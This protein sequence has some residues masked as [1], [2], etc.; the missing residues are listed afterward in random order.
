M[1]KLWLGHC[2]VAI[3]HRS[4]DSDQVGFFLLASSLAR[5]DENDAQS[6]WTFCPCIPCFIS[7]EMPTFPFSWRNIQ[8][9]SFKIIRFTMEVRILSVT[10]TSIR[11]FDHVHETETAKEVK[12]FKQWDP[13]DRSKI[14]QVLCIKEPVKQHGHCLSIQSVVDRFWLEKHRGHAV[15]FRGFFYWL[16]SRWGKKFLSTSLPEKAM[17]KH[18]LAS[19]RWFVI[20]RILS[21]YPGDICKLIQNLKLYR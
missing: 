5:W 19:G 14:H 8:H 11:P 9:S 1:S 7:L 10:P 15:V 13:V 3:I 17:K 2:K 21:F 16:V 20:S 18:L 12:W 6:A 4:A